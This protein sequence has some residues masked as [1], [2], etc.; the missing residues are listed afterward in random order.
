VG[1][2]I[3]NLLEPLYRASIANQRKAATRGICAS[4]GI[5]SGRTSL[6]ALPLQDPK[7]NQSFFESSEICCRTIYTYQ[8]GYFDDFCEHFRIVVPAL[9][10]GRS[11]N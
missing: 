6:V 4:I 9:C 10:C 8:D 11:Q 3:S 1:V 2:I 5:E 7:L